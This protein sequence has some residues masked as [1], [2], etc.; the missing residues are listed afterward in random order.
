MSTLPTYTH[1]G[2]T[3]P[4]TAALANCL[5]AA[6]MRAPHNGQP[7]SEA[8]LLGIGGGL[9][10]GYILWE[11]QQ[12]QAR[13]LVLGFRHSW[14]YPVRFL[15]TICDRIGADAVV[16]ETGGERTAERQLRA[17]IEAGT[18][19]V[20]WVDRAHMPYLQLPAGLKGH[21]GHFVA[22]AGQDGD[23][24]IIDDLAVR[25]FFVPTDDFAAARGRI[26]SYKNRLLIPAPL[27]G[28]A[29]DLPEAVEAGLRDCLA[30]L[31]AKSDS[32][33]LPAL[34]KWARMMTDRK[35]PK[36]WPMLFVDP[37]G[38]Y[39]L[40][41]SVFEGIA[42]DGTGGDGLRSL[43]AAFLDEAAP[44]V[45]RPALA[46]VAMRYRD[47]AADWVALAEAALPGSVP[48]FLQARELLRE[49]HE[50]L[51]AGGQAAVATNEPLT[52]RIQALHAAL[53]RAF[54]LDGVATDALFTDLAERLRAIHAKELAVAGALSEALV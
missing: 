19:P 40:L 39:G 10:A 6:G 34:K 18:P 9:G 28:S 31:T 41:Q 32:F 35:N 5:N 24:A 23:A 33:S 13:I 44:I 11:F 22:V 30:N 4:E 16:H 14:Q 29:P 7:Y 50:R 2:G 26:A 12:H 52:A 47:L 20:A 21:I 53:N 51:M 43:Y 42:L 48:D 8:L 25:P 27:P 49:R 46:E 37:R 3:H 36:G 38:L 1:F 45:G 54:P 17:A 15:E